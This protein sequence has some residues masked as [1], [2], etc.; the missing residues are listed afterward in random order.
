MNEGYNKKILSIANRA[1][2]D[3]LVPLSYEDAEQQLRAGKEG[4]TLAIFVA[5]ECCELA[6]G[7]ESLSQ[8]FEWAANGMRRAASELLRVAEALESEM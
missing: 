4:D 6:D 1:Y 2:P 5:I 8:A 3:S 7:A